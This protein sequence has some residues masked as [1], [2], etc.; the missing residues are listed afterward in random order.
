MNIHSHVR[1][2]TSLPLS[3]EEYDKELPI[4]TPEEVSTCAICN[5]TYNQEQFLALA[6][7]AGGGTWTYPDSPVEL[8]VR[9]CSCGNTLARRTA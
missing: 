4:P 7:A 6:P 9:Q 5:K 1:D 2:T 3:S 8:A